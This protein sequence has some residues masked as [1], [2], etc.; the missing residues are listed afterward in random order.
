MDASLNISCTASLNGCNFS[1]E[2]FLTYITG[3]ILNK[4][5][6]A[7]KGYDGYAGGIVRLQ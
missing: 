2:C 6:I 5:V 4:M 3:K 7:V 1:L